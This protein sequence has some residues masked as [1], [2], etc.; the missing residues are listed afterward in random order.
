MKQEDNSDQN[1]QE[2]VHAMN[3]TIADIIDIK[4]HRNVFAYGHHL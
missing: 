1:Q 4:R 2:T 3:D